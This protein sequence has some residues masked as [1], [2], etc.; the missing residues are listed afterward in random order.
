[1]RI[2]R[3]ELIDLQLELRIMTIIRDED[4]KL[5]ERPVEGCSS[6]DSIHNH[7]NIFFACSNDY[8]DTGHIVADDATLGSSLLSAE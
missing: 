2:E 6:S 7:V 3:L 4:A 1:M 8:I 5:V